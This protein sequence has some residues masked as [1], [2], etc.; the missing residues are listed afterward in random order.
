MLSVSSFMQASWSGQLNNCKVYLKEQSSYSGTQG[1]LWMPF[2]FFTHLWTIVNW[3]SWNL[4]WTSWHW[5]PL[6]VNTTRISL[7]SNTNMQAPWRGHL[8]I[9]CIIHFK[10]KFCF[11]NW[12]L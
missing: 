6:H 3:F 8:I 10:I 11:L 1:A 12:L 2:Y 9:W 7:F 5:R 4:V